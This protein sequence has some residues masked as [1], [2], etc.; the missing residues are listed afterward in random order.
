MLFHTASS[1]AFLR[2]VVKGLTCVVSVLDIRARIQQ[3]LHNIWMASMCCHQQGCVASVVGCMYQSV[4]LSVLQVLPD[5]W[6][7][8]LAGCGVQRG[9]I[10]C[11]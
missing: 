9:V 4:G 6:N 10:Y 7:I 1:E 8:P 3:Q 11:S 5:S 2:R